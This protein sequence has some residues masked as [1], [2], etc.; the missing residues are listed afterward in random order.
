MRI[1]IDARH[2][3]NKARGGYKTYTA[4]LLSALSQFDEQN[5]YFVYFD[6]EVDSSLLAPN[7]NFHYRV[8]RAANPLGT[9]LREQIA[10]PRLAAK[11]RVDLLHCPANTSPLVSK[12]NVVVTI[13]DAIR[14]LFREKVCAENLRQRVKYRCTAA[15][16]AAVI[17]RAAR[18]AHCIITVSETSRQDLSR[19]LGL[20][21]GTIHVAP[22]SVH[23]RF[24]VM[25]TSL[26][27]GEIQ[28]RLGLSG[29]LVM[30]LS[31]PENRKNLTGLI[32]V[33]SIV[34]R[35]LPN[36][37]FVVVCSAEDTKTRGLSLCSGTN[38]QENVTFLEGVSDDDLVLLYNAASVFVFPSLYEGFGLPPLEAMACGTPVVASDRGSLP[39]VL[40]DAA[41]L[42]DPLDHAG[43][44][45]AVCD[46]VKETPTALAWRDKGLRR[47]HL[48]SSHA[49]ATKVLEVYG[50]VCGVS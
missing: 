46:I 18:S 43:I 4:S 7:P 9:V 33:F 26:V 35:E 11:D 17:P 28:D 21:A 24:R 49:F 37:A 32:R 29:T 1:G 40:G 3:S 27:R 45:R 39:E 13:H 5:E 16:E 50:K 34:S 44:A 25:D 15:Y 20:D 42:L 41:R 23:P 38:L 47:A 8:L 12:V 31:G 36:T 19:C 2:L 10:L 22:L 6:S 30:G 48:F 14:F